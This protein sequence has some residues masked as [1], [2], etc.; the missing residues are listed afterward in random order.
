MSY[1]CHQL[2]K[3]QYLLWT[4]CTRIPVNILYHRMWAILRFLGRQTFPREP[5]APRG[6]SPL[7]SQPMSCWES[8]LPWTRSVLRKNLLN[9]VCTQSCHTVVVMTLATKREPRSARLAGCPHC[10]DA[11]GAGRG[12]SHATGGARGVRGQHEAHVM[13]MYSFGPTCI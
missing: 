2:E 12:A 5:A 9:S 13:Y 11:A 1:V 3:L 7:V 10:D 6:A 4:Y 8:G